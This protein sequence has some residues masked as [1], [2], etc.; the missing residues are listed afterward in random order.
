MENA[1]DGTLRQKPVKKWMG[2]LGL[3]NV[4]V[5]VLIAAL[6]AIV[7][8]PESLRDL[9]DDGSAVSNVLKKLENAVDENLDSLTLSQN[10]LNAYLDDTLLAET[11]DDFA[12]GLTQYEDVKIRLSDGAADVVMKRKVAGF[13]ST[14][15]IRL[16]V[17]LEEKRVKISIPSGRFGSLPVP[18]GLTRF[19]MPAFVSLKDAY[20]DEIKFMLKAKKITFEE[21]KV[22][23][24]FQQ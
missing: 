11:G 13:T 17:E 20:E 15:S 2:C 10:E 6:C 21:G 4:V 9:A 16:I 8:M 24:L 14:I 18:S 19:V 22:V 23:F 3:F 5:Y 1:A 7:L 12:G